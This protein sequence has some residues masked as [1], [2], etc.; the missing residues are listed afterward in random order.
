MV[1]QKPGHGACRGRVRPADPGWRTPGSDAS[2]IAWC[3]AAGPGRLPGDSGKR[4]GRAPPRRKKGR[5]ESS[6]PSARKRVWLRGSSHSI[7]HRSPR[8][9][10][11]IAGRPPVV[12]GG[13]H[14]KPL[15]RGPSRQVPIW[16][17]S[18]GWKRLKRPVLSRQASSVSF[19]RPPFS[20]CHLAFLL[21]QR[22]CGGSPETHESAPERTPCPGGHALRR[23]Q[24]RFQRGV[25]C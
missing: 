20:P 12:R 23:K 17:W 5:L 7:R 11:R 2:S 15:R 9:P 19:Y 24:F 22:A 6:L 4:A 1:K 25:V 3:A 18:T 21:A 8:V 14:G 16:G 13:G 10:P